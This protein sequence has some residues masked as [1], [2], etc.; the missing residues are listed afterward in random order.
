MAQDTIFKSTAIAFGVAD[1]MAAMLFLMLG[2]KYLKKLM[3]KD[4][5]TSLCKVI[6]S[7]TKL[8]LLS[9]IDHTAAL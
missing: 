4:I 9:Y 2:G 7:T 1:P 5:C 8:Y 6:V 3:I